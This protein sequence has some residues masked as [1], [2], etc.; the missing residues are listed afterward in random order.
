MTGVLEGL[1]VLDLTRGIAGAM[2]TMLLTDHGGTVTRIEQAGADPGEDVLQGGRIWHRGKASAVFDFHDPDDLET[3]RRLAIAADILVE[4]FAPGQSA[5]YGLEPAALAA[6]NPRL[7]HVSITGYGPD[8]AD[9]ERPAIDALVQARLGLMHEARGWDGGSIQRVIGRDADPS[10][11]KPVPDAI[12]TGSARSGPIF[13]ASPAPSVSAA[14]LAV[15]GASAALRAREL[16]GLGQHVATSLMQGAI[17][18]QSCGWQ[19]P[20]RPDAPGYMLPA[21]DRRQGWGIVKT[22]DRWVCTWTNPPDWAIA[23]AQGDELVRPDPEEV[24]ARVMARNG[25]AGRT[26]G[27]PSLD[28][29]LAALAEAAP[30]YAKFPA[31]DWARLAAECDSCV[32]PIRPAEEALLDPLLI[33]DGSVAIVEDEELGPLHQAGILFRLHDCP[34]RLKAPARPRGADTRAV[35]M[36]AGTAMPPPVQPMKADLSRGP[37]TGIRVVDLGLAVAGPWGAQLLGDLGADVIKIDGSRQGFWMPTSMAL[38]MNRTKRSARIELKDAEGYA[39]VR[40]LIDGADVVIHNMRKGVAER[41]GVDYAT[42]KATNPGLIY[43]HTRGF[44]DGPRAGL[45]GH[46]QAANSLGGSVWEDGG[47]D[48]GGRPFFGALT[49]GDLGNGYFAAIAI[50][51]ALY[52]RQRTGRGQMVDT[53]I[54]NASLFNN[55][56][57]FTTPEGRRF[58]RPRLDADQLGLSALYRLYR[59]ADGWLCLAVLSDAHWQALT[60]AIPGLASDPRF[61]TAGLRADND[62]ILA[63]RLADWFVDQPSDTAFARLD[64]A[65][66]PC[67]IADAEYSRRIFDDA[68]LM[69][70]GWVARTE[71][72]PTLGTLDLFGIGLDFSRTPIRPGGAPPTFGQQTREI[73]AEAGLDQGAIDGLYARSAAGG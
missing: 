41:L 52:H 72:H 63:N 46:D 43:C 29:Q 38:A 20:E 23:A 21:L 17:L 55:S 31:A 24:K 1:K 6:A 13:S 64:A 19:R 47:M 8:T 34:V 50:T 56:R 57:V 73:L 9:A 54:L 69:A 16:C 25:A 42:L 48:N 62:A 22:A 18:Y 60:R 36:I 37:L 32:Q 3:I 2:A 65:G 26:A 15:L 35:Q 10:G 44:E 49:G 27:M 70:R 7:I 67:E 5:E 30:Y 61:A 68:D 28:N 51:L 39:A 66:V 12:R 33:A 59:A 71:G 53:S 45:I 4:D 40:R 11:V 58:D 14:Y